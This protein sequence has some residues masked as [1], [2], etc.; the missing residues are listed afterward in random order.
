MPET[1]HIV[2]VEVPSSEAELAAHLMHELGSNGSVEERSEGDE[3][4]RVISYFDGNLFD[5]AELTRQIR[6]SLSACPAFADANA[7]L[8]SSAITDWSRE[9]RQWFRPFE[10]VPDMVVAPS[11]ENYR[12]RGNETIITLDP[13]MAFGTGLHATTKLCAKAVN[14]LKGDYI[15][16]SLLDVGTGSGIL[17]I[18]GRKLGISKIVAVENDPEARR[19]AGENIRRNCANDIELIA[20]ID[21]A[22][23]AYQLVVVNILLTTIVELKE[24]LIGKTSNGGH[25][26]LSGI[27]HDQED[28]LEGEF[29]GKVRLIDK[30]RLDE[31][32]S[33]IFKRER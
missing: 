1:W 20:D 33:M 9:W 23:G 13:G 22:E 14:H 27:T 30:N 18:V 29:S 10:I 16:P 7:D 21:D 15:S 31:W 25:I 17:A 26:I 28:N 32:S 11:W 12:A 2:T 3:K 5:K 8:K 24:K 19:V 4:T 6:R